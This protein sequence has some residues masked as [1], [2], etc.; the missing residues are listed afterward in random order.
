M[1][2]FKDDND[3]TSSKRVFG[4]IAI[5]IAGVLSFVGG[6]KDPTIIPQL[7]WSWLAFAAA[8]AGVSALE[9]KKG[10]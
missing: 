7:V 1:T 5:C 10:V 2:L 9:K 4:F 8:S 3:R 6:F